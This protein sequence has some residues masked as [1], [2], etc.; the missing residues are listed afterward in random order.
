MS[1]SSTVGV[2]EKLWAVSSCVIMNR[3]VCVSVVPVL[4][5]V[6]PFVQYLQNED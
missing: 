6:K 5:G 1:E 4:Y 3:S 2:T